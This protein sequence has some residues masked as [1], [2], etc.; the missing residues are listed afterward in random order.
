MD[1]MSLTF[2]SAPL[3]E[4]LEILGFP[5]V[6]LTLAADQPNA[7]VCVR[8]CEVFADGTSALITRAVQ[9]LTHRRSDEEPEPLVPGERLAATVRLDA[10]GHAFAAG[11]RIRVGISPTYW[12]WAWPSPRPVTL[13]VVAGAGSAL[14]LPVR[15]PR[16]E[17]AALAPFGAPEESAPMPTETIHGG[18]AGRTVHRDLATGRVDLVY[19]WD[20]GGRVRLPNGL[21]IEDLNRTTFSIVEGD[22]LSASVRCR[23]EGSVGRGAWR[24]RCETESVMTCDERRFSVTIVVHA[25]EGAACVFAS[26]WAGSFPRDLV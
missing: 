20:V 13:T 18:P 1:G 26:T 10:T 8:L 5:E 21:E 11:S 2:T 17:D 25:Y 19:D 23:T 14:R 7:L 6:D 15:P 16:G 22:P 9:N 4:R 12:P 24:T 3:P